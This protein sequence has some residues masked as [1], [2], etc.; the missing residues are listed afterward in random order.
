MWTSS[1]SSLVCLCIQLVEMLRS[2]QSFF[3]M[4]LKIL[5]SSPHPIFRLLLLHVYCVH[6][7]TELLLSAKCKTLR[8]E[9][10]TFSLLWAKVSALSKA[11]SHKQKTLI[12]NLC[13]FILATNSYVKSFCELSYQN[14]G[15]QGSQMICSKVQQTCQIFHYNFFLA[16]NKIQLHCRKY[17]RVL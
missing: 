14:L 9:L 13:D 10:A 1:I 3:V 17:S 11:A 2:L 8:H 5:W 15:I 6:F 7:L 16:A 4:K 12:K